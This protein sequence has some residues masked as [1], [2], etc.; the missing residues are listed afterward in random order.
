MTLRIAPLRPH[1]L[2]G[3]LPD[4]L[5]ARVRWHLHTPYTTVLG[6]WHGDRLAG[7]ATGWRLNEA[8]SITTLHVRPD[9]P[10]AYTALAEALLAAL[11]PDHAPCMVYA[12]PAHVARWTAL[13]FAPRHELVRVT[14]VRFTAAQRPAVVALEPHH[15]L[16]VFR[17]DRTATGLDRRPLL[18]EHDYLGQVYAEAGRVR[19]F[20]LPLLG[21]GLIV[22]DAPHVGLELQRWLFPV[23]P[24]VL[25]PAT[26]A[27][28][29]TLAEQGADVRTAAVC[30]VRGTL[31]QQ[32]ELL[33]AEPHGAVDGDWEEE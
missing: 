11:L 20:Y 9:A 30:L 8:A 23:Q 15:W 12:A 18:L 1:E 17:L 19:G 31:S 22:A 6:A 5:L 10:D 25:L 14:Q 16:A 29:A 33:Y 28:L 21:H 32:P 7:L 24:Q 26:S 4:R 13:G 3:H 2:P 27:A